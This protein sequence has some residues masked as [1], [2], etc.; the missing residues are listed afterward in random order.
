MLSEAPAQDSIQIKMV[1]SDANIDAPSLL[2]TDAL[3]VL[4]GH[5]SFGKDPAVVLALLASSKAMKEIVSTICSGTLSFNSF[6]YGLA[7]HP[8]RLSSFIKW[9]A[10]HGGLVGSLRTVLG[11]YTTGTALV[12]ALQQAAAAAPFGQ[13]QLHALNC[14]FISSSLLRHICS[15]CL[16]SLT[17]TVLLENSSSG[18]AAAAAALASLTNLRHLHLKSALPEL[19]PAL[20]ALTALQSLNIRQV[21]PREGLASA[22]IFHNG[23]LLPCS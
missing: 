2:D 1:G 7:A 6:R 23:N 19:K 16:R 13:L 17:I 15:R 5:Q 20:A 9:V 18:G 10:S 11:D 22:A 12:D 14:D 21:K 8:S 4:L 3:R